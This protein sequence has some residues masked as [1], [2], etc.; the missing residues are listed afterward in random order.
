M[1]EYNDFMTEYPGKQVTFIKTMNKAHD[2]FIV[3]DYGTK[4]MR[5]YLCG[6]SSK[7]SGNK[8]TAIVELKEVDVYNNMINNLLTNNPLN[9][10]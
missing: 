5:V 8:V 7:D 3:L 10:R 9:L 1:T 4:N 2:R 6:S